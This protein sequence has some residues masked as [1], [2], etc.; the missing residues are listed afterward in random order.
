LTQQP[1][2]QLEAASDGYSSNVMPRLFRYNTLPLVVLLI[3]LVVFK[4]IA[5]IG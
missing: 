4:V 3:I 5:L 1:Y 2:S